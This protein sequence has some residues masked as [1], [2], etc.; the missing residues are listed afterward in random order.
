MAKHRNYSVSDVAAWKFEPAQLPA[1]WAAHIG[2][3]SGNFRMLIEGAPGHG[4][5]EYTLQLTRMLALHVG[6]V[7]YNNVEQG[8]SVTL[9]EAF[10]RNQMQELPPGKFMV[11]DKSQRL[12][13]PWFKRLQR[14]NSGRIIV[15][16]SRDY[17]NLSIEQFKQLHE[18]FPHKSIIIVC[19]NDPMDANSKKIRYMC[20]IKVEVKNYKAHMRSRFGGNKTW[21]IWDKQ[22]NG[23]EPL[24]QS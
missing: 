15:L 7:N 12:F 18:R 8:R 6:K 1:N 5:T 2:K 3:L 21:L 11:C 14:P 22:L 19:W 20:D 13:E 4:K 17:M 23:Q 10:V 16:D 9:Q 24:F